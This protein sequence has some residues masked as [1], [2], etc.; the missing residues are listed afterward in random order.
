MLSPAFFEND[1]LSRAS[2]R[3]KTHF[4]Q[5]GIAK[6]AAS[7]AGLNIATRKAWRFH[8]HLQAC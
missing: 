6:N 5:Q 2:R 7:F 4:L 8:K 3:V 1:A